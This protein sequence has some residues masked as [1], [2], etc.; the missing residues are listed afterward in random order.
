MERRFAAH[1]IYLSGYGYLKN[2]AVELLDG[3]LARIFSL[4]EEIEDT[5]W[6]PGVIAV[7]ESPGLFPARVVPAF[8][9]SVPGEVLQEL[10]GYPVY[11]FYPFDLT[12]MSPVDGTRRRQ[13]Q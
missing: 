11:H 13:L 6:L 7:L 5:E 3:K 1:Y 2:C 10:S 12:F 8:P 9:S 4:T